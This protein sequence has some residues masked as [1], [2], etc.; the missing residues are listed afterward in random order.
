MQTSNH[1]N[2]NWKTS[3]KLRVESKHGGDNVEEIETPEFI[4]NTSG[5]EHN[6]VLDE[7]ETDFVA[8]VCAVSRCGAVVLYDKDKEK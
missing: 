7:T 2:D 1:S 8:Y 5:H 3:K 4:S 6:W